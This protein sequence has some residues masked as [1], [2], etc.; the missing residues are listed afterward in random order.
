VI[1]KAVSKTF[2]HGLGRIREDE[3]KKVVPADTGAT[4]FTSQGNQRTHRG[5][6]S[7]DWYPDH[8]Q[9]VFAPVCRRKI[10]LLHLLLFD[11]FAQ[12][13]ELS[14]SLRSA[15]AMPFPKPL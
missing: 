2:S 9:E 1:L 4:S 13:S 11:R 6:T 12:L 14:V 10:I 8:R 15:V 3:P 5:E 7:V